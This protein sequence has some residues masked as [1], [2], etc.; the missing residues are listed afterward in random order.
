MKTFKNVLI[1]I[2]A[3]AAILLLFLLILGIKVLAWLFGIFIVI[4]II[5]WIIYMVGK[6]RGHHQAARQDTPPS[7]PVSKPE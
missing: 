4:F 5:G 1:A 6:A 2:G 7:A 3:I